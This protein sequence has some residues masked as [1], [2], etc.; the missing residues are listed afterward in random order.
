MLQ[1]KPFRVAVW[2]LMV[3]LIILVGSKI[4]FVFQPAVTIVRALFFPV[5]LSGLLYYWFFPVVDWLNQQGVPRG[6]SIILLYCTIA[7]VFIILIS[8]AGPIL[9][10]QIS[11]LIANA[12][13]LVSELRLRL[14]GLQENEWVARLFGGGAVSLEDLVNQV[15]SLVSNILNTIAANI[16]PIITVTATVVTTVLIIPFIL[17]YMLLD[18]D[19]LPVTLVKFLPARHRKEADC[20]L[21]DMDRALSSYIQGQALVSLFV[22]ILALIGYLLIG[23]DYALI[24][25]IT[26]TV[27]NVVPFIGPIVGTAPAVIVGLIISPSMAVKALV[28]MLVVQQLESLFISPRIMGKK[29]SSHPVSIILVIIAAGKLAGFLGILLAIPSFAVLRVIVSH[30]YSIVSLYREPIK[31]KA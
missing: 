9:Q 11:S 28:V 26:A 21:R 4:S 3:F 1:S 10:R 18:G 17:F 15:I 14:L 5:V 24:L 6:L 23:L 30:T 7:S 2:V 22:G 31:P 29:F 8:Y 20:V 19:K 27:T 13:R 25:A 16:T 12:P